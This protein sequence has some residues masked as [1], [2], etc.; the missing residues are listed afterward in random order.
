MR[1]R[2]EATN[3]KHV[4]FSK[5]AELNGG[6]DASGGVVQFK[7][8]DIVLRRGDC[9]SQHHQSVGCGELPWVPDGEGSLE[10]GE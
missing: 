9:A 8:E 10:R 6:D 5:A 7:A 2:A 1:G 3:D 4:G